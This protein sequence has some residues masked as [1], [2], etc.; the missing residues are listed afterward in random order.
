[1]ISTPFG[2]AVTWSSKYITVSIRTSCSLGR[3]ATTINVQRG[4]QPASGQLAG[5]QPGTIGSIPGK[6]APQAQAA[7]RLCRTFNQVTVASLD[8]IIANSR[9]LVGGNRY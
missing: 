8:S 7:D 6:L 2:D 3:Y 5:G 1:M 9:Q 4:G